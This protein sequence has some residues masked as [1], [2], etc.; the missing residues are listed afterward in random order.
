SG[1]G[2]AVMRVAPDL[3][4]TIM[5]ANCVTGTLTAELEFEVI[6]SDIFLSGSEINTAAVNEQLPPLNVLP[7]SKFRMLRANGQGDHDFDDDHD[8]SVSC[9]E[10]KS[11]AQAFAK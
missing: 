6:D 3:E 4:G 10:I 1:D 7:E 11:H 9:S 8:G 2:Y 5:N